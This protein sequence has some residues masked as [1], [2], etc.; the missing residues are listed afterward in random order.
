MVKSENYVEK[1]QKKS[2]CPLL[3]NEYIRGIL[4]FLS[5]MSKPTDKHQDAEMF[6]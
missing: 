1:K 3:L 5:F 4:V 2:L 6:C